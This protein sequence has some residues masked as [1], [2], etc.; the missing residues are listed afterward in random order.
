MKPSSDFILC[1]YSLL[2]IITSTLVG[3]LTLKFLQV[4]KKSKI[5]IV[6]M[7]LS[8]IPLIICV[9]LN[10]IYLTNYLHFTINDLTADGL[11]STIKTV[12]NVASEQA[13][14]FLLLL[15]LAS[16]TELII[17]NNKIF[18]GKPKHKIRNRLL[19]GVFVLFSVYFLLTQTEI[20]YFLITRKNDFEKTYIKIY[21]N[22]M[23]ENTKNIPEIITTST[24]N[25]FIIQLESLS[26]LI[27]SKEITPNLFDIKNDG[28]FYKNVQSASTNTIRNIESILCR[29]PPALGNSL[30]Q[31][32]ESEINNL[33]CLPKILKK[34][35]YTTIF[36]KHSDVDLSNSRNF[37]EHIG[38]DEFHDVDIFSPD[39]KTLTWG[40]PDNIA[41][42]R[43]FQYLEKYKNK[44]LFVYME[45]GAIN[46]VPFNYYKLLE[47]PKIKIPA[48]LNNNDFVNRF[49]KST[50]LQDKYFGE[51]YEKYYLPEYSKNTSLLVFGDHPLPLEI[52]KNNN[53]NIANAYEENILTSFLLIKPD[54]PSQ[55]RGVVVDKHYSYNL[56]ID[57]ILELGGFKTK[58]KDDNA[59][60]LLSVQPFTQKKIVVKIFPIKYVVDIYTQKIEMFDLLTDPLETSPKIVNVNLQYL[61]N[62]CLD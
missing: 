5:G 39:D 24:N 13:I 35:G 49:A 1:I 54:L 62:N 32:S 30:S 42:Q 31:R 57:T 60:C 38:F 51:A 16:I 52:H 33:K 21:E 59:K 58:P 46:H 11:F 19:A 22:K 15:I 14:D 4:S 53:F 45:V 3:P 37:L 48:N 44:K 2:T 7:L 17:F 23:D 29:M 26:S 27:V 12:I 25:I 56:I 43:Y 47:D 20:N 34:N 8:P 28:L 9:S 40:H 55:E 61:L 18:N 10:T 50:W 41:Y 36:L 6:V